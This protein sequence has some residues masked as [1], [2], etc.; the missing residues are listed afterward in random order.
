MNIGLPNQKCGLCYVCARNIKFSKGDE[1]ECSMCNKIF[2][3]RCLPTHHKHHVPDNEDA[4]GFVCHICYNVN[5]N[6]SD[7]A[8][9][10]CMSDD[11]EI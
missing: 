6:D 9:C 7:D 1:L 4:D 8:S 11:G 10:F 5:D 3:I 2:H